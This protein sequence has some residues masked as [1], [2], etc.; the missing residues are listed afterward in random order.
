MAVAAP[1]L[2]REL[3]ESLVDWTR[4]LPIGS[5]DAGLGPMLMAGMVY[6]VLL[7]VPFLPAAEVGLLLM[8]LVGPRSAPLVYGFTLTG[9]TMA[10]AIGRWL[11]ATCWQ[12]LLQA[13]LLGK[14]EPSR[15]PLPA[16]LQNDRWV[17]YLAT[18]LLLNLPGNSGLGGGG[19]ISL[20][21]GWSRRLSFAGFLGTIAVATAPVPLLVGMGWLRID[22]ILTSTT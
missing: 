2:A 17:P 22:L 9:L 6:A 19:G 18:A 15:L 3:T 13:P 1:E 8:L 21:G 5:P 4:T 10:F 12:R 7:C 16:W 11:P 14:L 20:L